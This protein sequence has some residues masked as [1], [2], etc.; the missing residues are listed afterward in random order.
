[1]IEKV[2]TYLFAIFCC[3]LFF[4]FIDWWA[5]QT[6]DKPPAPRLPLTREQKKKIN[7]P[8]K[9]N[10]TALDTLIY[11]LV[12]YLDDSIKRIE[13]HGLNQKPMR[14]ESEA[15]GRME[16]EPEIARPKKRYW[17][18]ILA[19]PRVWRFTTINTYRYR[20][21]KRKSNMTS[22]DFSNFYKNTN[23][24]NRTKV[25]SVLNPIFKNIKG[26]FGVAVSFGKNA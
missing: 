26:R 5:S 11:E 14:G 2:G 3:W 23:Q 13:V 7:Y 12:Y 15:F 25:V 22:E 8:Y 17:I 4:R 1:M 24:R 9:S 6:P 21:G 18:R 10:G 16:C 19:K 20:L